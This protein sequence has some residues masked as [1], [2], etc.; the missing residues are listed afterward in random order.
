MLRIWLYLVV[1]V[2]SAATPALATISGEENPDRK[3]VRDLVF[4]II[5]ARMKGDAE[6]FMSFCAPEIVTYDG[7][8]D[9]PE[10]WWVEAVGIDSVRA[11]LSQSIKDEAALFAKHPDWHRHNEVRHVTTTGD[12]ALAVSQ[13]F[14]VV[15]GAGKGEWVMT[16]WKTVWTLRR[17][18][19]VWKVI[20]LM[21]LDLDQRQSWTIPTE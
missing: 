18:N 7:T 6:R 16:G 3:Q 2:M 21:G 17:T 20:G 13:H 1:A 19:G 9:D 15:A 12:G 14:T 5:D 11:A 8:P 4:Q 10:L